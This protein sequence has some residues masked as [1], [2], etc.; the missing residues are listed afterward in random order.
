MQVPNIVIIPTIRT[1]CHYPEP[2]WAKRP[3]QGIQRVVSVL[4]LLSDSSEG[5]GV[6]EVAEKLGLPKS[7]A[8]RILQALGESHLVYQ[9]ESTKKYG[10]GM[11]V[12]ALGTRLLNR[13]DIRPVAEPYLYQLKDLLGET[14]FLSLWE[15][16]L[17]I[18][19]HK[20][21]TEK[22]LRYFVEVGRPM[23]LH[24][25][26]AAKAILAYLP[27]G[28]LARVMEDIRFERYN[29]RT[30]TTR[31][32]FTRELLLTRE[33]GYSVCDREM[34]HL[35][36]AIGAPVFG[37]DGNVLGSITVLGPVDRFTDDFM[38]RA[39]EAVKACARRISEHMGPGYDRLHG[40]NP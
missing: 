2:R 8:F 29:A 10:L 32:A 11:G 19:V 40:G 26:A 21:E 12:L 14:V 39:G 5:L 13:L 23:P 1:V 16:G 35:V 33:R 25:T 38:E 15:K 18:C 22:N 24:C 6:T 30:C 9:D 17:V 7:T 27:E 3:M 36:K 20:V 28:E 31:E 4:K 34:E 37:S